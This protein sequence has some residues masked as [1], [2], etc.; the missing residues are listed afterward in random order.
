M[1]EGIDPRVAFRRGL[2]QLGEL[3]IAGEHLVLEGID[4]HVAFRQC[5]TQLGEFPVLGREFRGQ[6]IDFPAALIQLDVELRDPLLSA[7]P[8]QQGRPKDRL[9]LG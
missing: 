6:P 5:L 2:T 1:L 3:S 8:Q 4:A 9:G 7:L